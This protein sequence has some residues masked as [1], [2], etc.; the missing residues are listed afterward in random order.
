MEVQERVSTLLDGLGKKEIS[1]ALKGVKQK[2]NVNIF[3]K[4]FLVH[5]NLILDK[6]KSE[7]GKPEL[8]R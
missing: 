4:K 1:C 5:K 8:L 3:L 7:T 6:K 2:L